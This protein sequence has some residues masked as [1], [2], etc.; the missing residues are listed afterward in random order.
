[1]PCTTSLDLDFIFCPDYNLDPYVP[2]TLTTT[3]LHCQVG[4]HGLAAH[5]RVHSCMMPSCRQRWLPRMD[6]S[7]LCAC[8][9]TSAQRRAPCAVRRSGPGRRSVA[10][11][12]VEDH[13]G[14]PDAVECLAT[15]DASGAPQVLAHLLPSS[16]GTRMAPTP[17]ARTK[18]VLL[19]SAA[20]GLG[21]RRRRSHPRRIG[22]RR[23][24]QPSPPGAG[25]R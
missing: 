14:D 7:S 8:T 6:A 9:W 16:P 25:C 19:P 12:E 10:C 5:L 4:E 24:A 1:M 20:D 3:G 18:L 23:L 17:G 13:L 21:W 22:R 2:A 15:S 11:H